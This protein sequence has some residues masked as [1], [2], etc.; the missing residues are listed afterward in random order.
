MYA[1]MGTWQM[2]QS[3][4]EH[5]LSVLR[6]RIVPGVRQA[7]GLVKGYWSQDPGSDRSFSFVVFDSREAADSFAASVHGNTEAQSQNGVSM[8][9]LVVVEIAAET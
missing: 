9:A 4:C 7:P 3:L 8:L 1:V 5:Q 2:A 6:D